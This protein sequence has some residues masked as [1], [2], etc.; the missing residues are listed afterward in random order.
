MSI[1]G[2]VA[3]W[4]N[5]FI[6]RNLDG[7]TKEVMNGE[8][9]GKTVIPLP[10]YGRLAFNIAKPLGTCFLTDQRS[11]SNKVTASSRVQSI[12]SFSMAH[13]GVVSGQHSTSGTTALRFD[14]GNTYDRR[15]ADLSRCSI[16]NVYSVDYDFI[17]SV[18]TYR[19]D[20]VLIQ[21]Y[22]DRI[23][24]AGHPRSFGP[25]RLVETK[26][27]LAVH[28][29]GMASD[30]LV[31]L[32]ADVNYDVYFLVG[33]DLKAETII[34]ACLGVVD[35]FPAFECYTSYLGS[36]MELFTQ[37]SPPGNTAIDLLGEADTPVSG[38]VMFGQPLS[39]GSIFGR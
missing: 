20:P 23:S 18:Y 16:S 14:D 17:S 38:A 37:P 2:P 22:M 13:I 15:D 24:F 29:V 9:R 25:A 1:I 4:I 34:V 26:Q 10:W 31:N 19:N 39:L 8:N 28:V 12:V 6:P 21:K 27:G 3:V 5:A 30:P 11:F 33:V 7:V 36:T 35:A 32:A